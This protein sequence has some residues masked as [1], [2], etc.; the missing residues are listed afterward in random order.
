MYLAK[1]CSDKEQLDT[2]YYLVPV[3]N[4]DTAFFPKSGMVHLP[5]TGHYIIGFNWGPVLP[6]PEVDITDTSLHVMRYREPTIQL[7]ETGATDTP[8]VYV[9]CDSEINGY[10]EDYYDDGVLKMR[11]NFENGN[12]KDSLVT[13]YPNGNLKKQLFHM[14]RIIIIKEF[15]TLGNLASLYKTENKGFMVY[16]EYKETTFFPNGK[17]ASEESSIKHV[18]RRLEF[19]PSGHIKL[20]QAKSYRINTL[21][22]V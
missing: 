1:S 3:N 9:K 19:Y 5:S 8:P 6:N 13:F 21:Q 18:V 17:I 14:P 15:D 7:Y 22:M 16:R 10:Q 4:Y 12:P 20:K 2:S 11:G